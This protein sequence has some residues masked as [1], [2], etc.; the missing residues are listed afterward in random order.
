MVPGTSSDA[1]GSTSTAS[2]A[3]ILA[4]PTISTC[5]S[6]PPVAITS[7]FRLA[8]IRARYKARGFTKEVIDILL[9][10]WAIATHKGYA[11]AWNAWVRWC[12]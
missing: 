6:M 11:G 4:I 3:P 10:S 1:C 2:L 8:P 5:S 9:A 12:S 7:P